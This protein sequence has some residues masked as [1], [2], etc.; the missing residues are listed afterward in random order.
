MFHAEIEHTKKVMLLQHAEF[1]IHGVA[2][3]MEVINMEI[4]EACLYLALALLYGILIYSAWTS[5][6][7]YQQGFRA[8]QEDVAEFCYKELRQCNGELYLCNQQAQSKGD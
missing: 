7:A 4:G 5:N 8:G 6:S 2:S 3:K 1:V